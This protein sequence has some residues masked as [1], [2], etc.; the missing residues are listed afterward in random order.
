MNLCYADSAEQI[1]YERLLNRLAQ[2]GY[3]VGTQQVS[4]LPV[5]REEFNDLAA[6]DL[7]PKELEARALERLAAQKRR[8]QSMEI[9]AKDLYEI[10]L[11]LKERYAEQK[12]PITLDDIWE[13]LAEA[14]YLRGLGCTV[15]TEPHRRMTLRGLENVVDG[16]LLTV[17]R[18]LFEHGTREGEGTLHF[19][20]YGDDVFDQILWLYEAHGLPGCVVRLS[21][22]VPDT[23]CKVVAYVAACLDGDGNRKVRLITAMADLDGL[24]LDESAVLTEEQLAGVRQQLHD[25]VSKEFD[26]TR[27]VPRLEK[28]NRQV[29]HAQV[30]LDLL[31]ADSLFPP[32]DVS[33]TENFWTAVNNLYQLAEQRDALVIPHMPVTDLQGLRHK[34]LF[35]VAT[36]QVG[37]KTSPTV[38]IMLVEAGL[39]AACRV[40][41]SMRRARAELTIE[42][43]KRRLSRD[44]SQHVNALHHF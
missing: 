29:A 4:M 7:T 14:K 30:L 35:D 3:V 40:A 28:E 2:A 37:E 31:V 41:H 44:I 20:S 18:N 26:P 43:V 34:T 33:P 15:A 39:D 6:G 24:V 32:F 38:P 1:V 23:H 8:S 11:R 12:L 17:D 10:Y 42:T 19:G 25:L 21:E 13:V 5:T 9:P 22:T 16:T 36:P 27:A